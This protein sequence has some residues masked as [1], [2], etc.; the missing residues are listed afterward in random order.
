M[1]RRKWKKFLK[2]LLSSVIV[3]FFFLLVIASTEQM[4]PP[5]GCG[6]PGKFIQKLPQR[7]IR[8]NSEVKRFLR[9][10]GFFNDLTW[11]DTDDS[12]FKPCK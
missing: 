6:Q 9:W 4:C 8:P 2:F 10:T 12:F 1:I 5:E 7:V 3:S 11:Q